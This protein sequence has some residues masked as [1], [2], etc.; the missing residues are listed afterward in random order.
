MPTV[1]GANR[2][3]LELTGLEE[4]EELWDRLRETTAEARAFATANRKLEAQVRALERQLSEAGAL[5]DD[6]LVA[7]LPKRMTRALEAAQGVATEII[8]RAKKREAVIGHRA[9]ESARSIVQQAEAEASSIVMQ[10]TKDAAALIATAEAEALDLVGSAHDRRTKI[11]TDLEDEVKTLEQRRRRLRKDQS[12]LVRAYEI[13]ERTLAE[14][15]A[16]LGEVADPREPNGSAPSDHQETTPPP[17]D[18]RV[19]LRP[20]EP[21]LHVYDWSP[22]RSNAG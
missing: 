14:S 11:L 5:T 18:R 21:R 9:E 16:A 7:E 4:P 12:R 1:F 2:R 19:G 6:E 8:S 17:G 3:R 20:T 15:R 22:P 10:A 13:V